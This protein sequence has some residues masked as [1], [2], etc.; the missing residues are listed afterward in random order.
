LG[1]IQLLLLLLLL[2]RLTRLLD[3]NYSGDIVQGDGVVLSKHEIG[4]SLRGMAT[5]T[6]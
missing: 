3:S 4:R 1:R 5:V 6:S 2:L